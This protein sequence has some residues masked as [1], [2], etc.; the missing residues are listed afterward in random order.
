MIRARFSWAWKTLPDLKDGTRNIQLTLTKDYQIGKETKN[1][2]QNWRPLTTNSIKDDFQERVKIYK[3][4]AK[5]LRGKRTTPKQFKKLEQL[6][7]EGNALYDLYNFYQALQDHKMRLELRAPSVAE[8]LVLLQYPFDPNRFT[9]P[10]DGGKPIPTPKPLPG[11]SDDEKDA[12]EFWTFSR[13]EGNPFG[14]RPV[15]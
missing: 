13:G 3:K 15:R 1:G 11:G 4:I 5:K 10:I 7:S 14:S 6:W 8:E 9:G 2:K 12:E